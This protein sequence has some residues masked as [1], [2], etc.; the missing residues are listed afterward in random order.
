M[1]MVENLVGDLVVVVEIDMV[2]VSM[3]WRMIIVG[4]VLGIVCGMS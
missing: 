4:K 1:G 3:A 2:V